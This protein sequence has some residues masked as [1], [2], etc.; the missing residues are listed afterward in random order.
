MSLLLP[1]RKSKSDNR[2]CENRYWDEKMHQQ[3]ATW[4][5]HQTGNAGIDVSMD[6]RI[7][8]AAVYT[9][10]DLAPIAQWSVLLLDTVRR[11]WPVPSLHYHND[12]FCWRNEGIRFAEAAIT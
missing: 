5:H 11:L 8:L 6:V 4:S 12:L 3:S 9:E 1:H 10:A 2:R 7:S